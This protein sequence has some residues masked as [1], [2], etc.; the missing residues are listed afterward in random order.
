MRLCGC[1]MALSL[2]RACFGSRRA[3]ASCQCF[4][5]Y[6][7]TCQPDGSFFPLRRRLLI[8]NGMVFSPMLPQPRGGPASGGQHRR[9]WM[10]FGSKHNRS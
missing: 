3:S 4:N 2:N 1:W 10:L 6:K 9:F 7:G 5:D 8:A